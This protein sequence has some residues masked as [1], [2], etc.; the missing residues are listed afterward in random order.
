MKN[1]KEAAEYLR[2]NFKW[3]K[4]EASLK[5]INLVKRRFHYD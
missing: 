3:K 4:N 1:E 5:F 2:V